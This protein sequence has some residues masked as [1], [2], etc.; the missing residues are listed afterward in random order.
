MV[1]SRLVLVT[2]LC[3]S[4]SRKTRDVSQ[5]PPSHFPPSL[6]SVY[7]LNLSSCRQKPPSALF[8]PRMNSSVSH[9]LPL[10]CSSVYSSKLN[11]DNSTIPFHFCVCVCACI[12]ARMCIYV[13]ACIVVFCNTPPTPPQ[14]Q[15]C[16][17][18]YHGINPQLR[19]TEY[20]HVPPFCYLHS[21]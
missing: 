19:L 1:G 4:R 18:G 2:S 17:T 6:S 11:S 7:S 12:C 10:T 14:T 13:C 8:F 20:L 3:A 5:I 9:R 16:L 21:L 15:P